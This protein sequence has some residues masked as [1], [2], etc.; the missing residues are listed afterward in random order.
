MI[1][2]LRPL[3]LV[4]CATLVSA[5]AAAHTMW[6]NLAPDH[7][8]QQVVTSVAYGDYLPGSE[9]L[10]T[11]WGAMRLATYELLSPAGVRAD[12]VP[13]DV[14]AARARELPGGARIT[15]GGD[16]GQRKVSLADGARGTYLVLGQSPAF[17][18]VH[19]RGKDGNDHYS[20]GPESSIADLSEVLDVSHEVF[21]LKSAFAA[22]GWTETAPAKQLFE[23]VP[24]TDLHAVRPGD[25]VRLRVLLRGKPWRAAH[26]A[27]LLTAQNQALGD[28][29]GLASPLASGV[30]EFRLPTAGLWRFDARHDAEAAQFPELV[31]GAKPGE[32]L[33]I[34]SSF[35]V[36]VRP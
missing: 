22:G 36:H 11:E 34:N 17:R 18:Y 21:F 16:T 1:Y 2:M 14:G 4:C 33:T 35:T 7:A 26:G 24:L 27:S 5:P 9:L 31:R 10:R 12:L 8:E 28:R 19:Y 32:E 15:A 25:I 23:I 30:A 20:D 29:W 3:A 6:I 13:P